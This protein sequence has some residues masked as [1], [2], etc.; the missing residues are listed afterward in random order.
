MS[1]SLSAA[2]TFVS[3]FLRKHNF[4]ADTVISHAKV[5]YV[6]IRQAPVT[7]AIISQALFGKVSAQDNRVTLVRLGN[8]AVCV[9]TIAHAEGI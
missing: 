3:A 1:R 5:A 8:A 2:L 6:Q 9:V 4:T 7:L